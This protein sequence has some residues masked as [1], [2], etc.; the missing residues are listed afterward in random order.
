M[1]TAVLASLP[2]IVLLLAAQRF[3]AAGATGGAVK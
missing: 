2:A 3:I 1:A